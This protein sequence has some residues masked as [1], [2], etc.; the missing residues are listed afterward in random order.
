MRI[1]QIFLRTDIP[2]FISKS[3][4]SRKHDSYCLAVSPLFPRINVSLLI[5]AGPRFTHTAEQKKKR[6]G[7]ERGLV[8]LSSRSSSSTRG[9][10]FTNDFW[11]GKKEQGLF[12]GSIYICVCTLYIRLRVVGN[13]FITAWKDIYERG[14]DMRCFGA[15]FLID[16]EKLPGRRID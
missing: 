6:V 11:T 16:V 2:N 15:R 9:Y 12:F 3:I 1:D 7:L 14:G 4:N 13:F 8:L 10:T 5:N